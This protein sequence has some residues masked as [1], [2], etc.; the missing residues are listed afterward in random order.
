MVVGLSL[1]QTETVC[2]HKEEDV[3]VL[4]RLLLCASVQKAAG[5]SEKTERN[6]Q[7]NIPKFPNHI[8]LSI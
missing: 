5:I 8:K 6:R 4:H 7:F 2:V 3:L 1:G